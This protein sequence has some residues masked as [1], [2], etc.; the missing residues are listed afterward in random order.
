MGPANQTNQPTNQPANQPAKS[1]FPPTGQE[2]GPRG[3]VCRVGWQG[4][5]ELLQAVDAQVAQEDVA[6][7][8]GEAQDVLGEARRRGEAHLVVVEHILQ[9]LHNLLLEATKED[10]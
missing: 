8:V 5:V 6:A 4:S 10:I 7:A 3:V 9:V 1:L 2:L